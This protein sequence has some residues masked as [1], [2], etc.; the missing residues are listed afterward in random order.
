[1][2]MICINYILWIQ[3]EEKVMSF[4]NQLN[5]NHETIKF[6]SEH[7]WGSIDFLDVQETFREEG[8]LS[9]DLICK[10]TDAHQ[11]LRKK[12]CHP[13]HTKKTSEVKK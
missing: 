1:M 13:W 10:P 4:T 12:Q 11:Y 2:Y 7:S 3:G 5:S 6:T 9:P 8:V